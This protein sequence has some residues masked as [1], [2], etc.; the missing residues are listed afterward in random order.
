ML[1]LAIATAIVTRHWRRL[2]N[3][4]RTWTAWR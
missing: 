1:S 2:R 4:N 3:A